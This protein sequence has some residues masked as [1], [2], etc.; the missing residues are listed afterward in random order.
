MLR[1]N[2]DP[3]N[4]GLVQLPEVK[5]LVNSNGWP[6]SCST[7]IVYPGARLSN[8]FLNCDKPFEIRRNVAIFVFFLHVHQ[9]TN[10]LV[11]SLVIVCFSLLSSVFQAY[12][13]NISW[14][15]DPFGQ[16]T[17]MA[18]LVRKMGFTGMVIGRVHYEVK[19][20]LALR[21]ALEFHWGQSWG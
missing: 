6:L 21:K 11:L 18:Y 2:A 12:R 7:C 1:C 17:T 8:C 14:S 16:S 15:I 19:K 3:R 20:Y 9:F 5:T 4:I 10:Q 13:P